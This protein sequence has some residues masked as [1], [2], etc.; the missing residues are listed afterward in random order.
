MRIFAAAVMLAASPPLGEFT[1]PG[2]LKS[3]V[4]PAGGLDA[5]LLPAHGALPIG[6]RAAGIPLLTGA[7]G[8]TFASEA[9]TPAGGRRLTYAVGRDT[10][11]EVML[12][13]A[14]SGTRGAIR[15]E[16]RLMG[17]M[18]G[19]DGG[20]G[21]DVARAWLRAVAPCHWFD[22]MPKPPNTFYRGDGLRLPLDGP[23]AAERLDADLVPGYA[24]EANCYAF[25][26]VGAEL[27]PGFPWVTPT[28]PLLVPQ[29]RW[30]GI[31]AE[32]SSPDAL[33]LARLRRRLA[34]LGG[35]NDPDAPRREA[36]ALAMD[37]LRLAL[38]DYATDHEGRYPADLRVLAGPRWP[39]NPWSSPPK[40]APVA[41]GAWPKI[42]PTARENWNGSKQVPPIATDLGPGKLPGLGPADA[43]TYG[44]ILYDRHVQG[45]IETWVLYRVGKAGNRAVLLHFNGNA[46]G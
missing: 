29:G 9:T 25:R 21:P 44:A 13:G 42:L 14:P 8:L 17:V 31:R 35:P 37:R 5:N 41:K 46:A 40:P 11:V 36:A 10:I 23:P 34:P 24:W 43:R 38:E 16:E 12:A 4:V 45:T 32:A 18:V 15:A 22:R 2:D 28:R 20:M 19:R 3:Q 30:A 6:V 7:P 26:Y 33:A 39:P 1:C 27:K